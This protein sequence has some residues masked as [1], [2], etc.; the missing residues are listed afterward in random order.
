MA[1]GYGALTSDGSDQ[2]SYGGV[3]VV[4]VVGFSGP[5]T[6]AGSSALPGSVVPRSSTHQVT[7]MTTMLTER[8]G[9]Q[10]EPPGHGGRVYGCPQCR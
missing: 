6:T 4:V 8:D 1:P 3:V 5:A 10:G 7:A 9:E 2:P